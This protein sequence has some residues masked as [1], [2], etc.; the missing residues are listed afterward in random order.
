MISLEEEISNSYDATLR[1]ITIVRRRIYCD[2][3]IYG[4]TTTIEEQND[5]RAK[6]GRTIV[7]IHQIIRESLMHVEQEGS[8]LHK[9]EMKLEQSRTIYTHCLIDPQIINPLLLTTM[10]DG[11]DDML[12]YCDLQ[13]ETIA[14][15][16][17]AEIVA[18]RFELS[19]MVCD[20][21]E[22]LNFVRDELTKFYLDHPYRTLQLSDRLS[23][24]LLTVDVCLSPAFLPYISG[25]YEM[26]K[27]MVPRTV[28]TINDARRIHQRREYVKEEGTNLFVMLAKSPKLP[29]VL[30]KMIAEYA[31]DL[32]KLR[33]NL[34]DVISEEMLR[35]HQYEHLVHARSIDI[36]A[37]VPSIV[38]IV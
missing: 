38:I 8:I 35:H 28:R 31:V 34:C 14:V 19:M 3:K 24:K 33:F 13:L 12:E 26:P 4:L 5:Q 36:T 23:N 9:L 6:Y 17:N 15:T 10:Y 7:E 20:H 1:S 30:L 16:K 22:F 21:I 27:W 32:G 37:R 25:E 29:L 2:A 11:I 18:K